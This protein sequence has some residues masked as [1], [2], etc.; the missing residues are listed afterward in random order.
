MLVVLRGTLS[1]EDVITDAICG[2]E[3][4]RV[5]GDM[6]GFNGVDRF[7]HS[8]MLRAAQHIRLELEML[9]LLD[10]FGPAAVIFYFLISVVLLAH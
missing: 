6:W 1:L 3:E 7:A 8:G 9:G 2:G 4:L 5:T 10:Q